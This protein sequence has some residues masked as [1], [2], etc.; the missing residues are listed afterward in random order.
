MKTIVFRN[1]SNGEVNLTT[2]GIV[3]FKAQA[4]RAK[5]LFR[6]REQRIIK[7]KFGTDEVEA[8]IFYNGTIAVDFPYGLKA[9]S[10][11]ELAEINLSF[12]GR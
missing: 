4:E 10:K 6:R 8:E 5:N 9:G 2:K 12:R 7:L 1:V 11:I 3:E